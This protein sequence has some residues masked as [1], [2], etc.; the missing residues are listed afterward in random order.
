MLSFNNL[1]VCAGE[2]A[3][4]NPSHRKAGAAARSLHMRKGARLQQGWS[5]NKIITRKAARLQQGLSHKIITRQLARLQQGLS[6]NKIIAREDLD[7]YS[8]D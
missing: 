2:S 1:Q 8:W 4:N 3:S 5:H 7:A 6:H